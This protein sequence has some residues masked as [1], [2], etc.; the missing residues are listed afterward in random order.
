MCSK[1][2]LN[3]LYLR[4]PGHW[5]LWMLLCWEWEVTVMGKGAL[6]LMCHLNKV[7]EINALGSPNAESF[8]TS[9]KENGLLANSKFSDT[10]TNLNCCQI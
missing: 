2:E 5:W 1:T 7:A 4:F 8:Y 6:G 9:L 3:S 10:G